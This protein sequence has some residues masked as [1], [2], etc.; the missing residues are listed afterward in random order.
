M[1][2]AIVQRLI[3]PQPHA[4]TPLVVRADRTDQGRM[5]DGVLGCPVCAHEWTVADG[6]ARFGERARLESTVSTDA[7]TLAALLGL[8][9]PHVVVLDGTTPDAGLLSSEFGAA[10]IALDAESF[11][12]DATNIEGSAIVPLAAGVARGVALLRAG[13]S[14]EFVASAVRALAQEGR[15]V[16]STVLPL[17]AGV[18]E[19]A[20]NE[21]IWVAEREPDPVVVSLRRRT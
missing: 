14:P 9:D 4:T 11:L 8:T 2:L 19:I 6:I 3:C 15:L 16:S 21:Q 18:R 10:V 7:S 17:P 13:R 5:V 12:P 1:D 20:R